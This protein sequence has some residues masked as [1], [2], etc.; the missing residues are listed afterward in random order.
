M[1]PILEEMIDSLSAMVNMN[2]GVLIGIGSI[3]VAVVLALIAMLFVTTTRM[4]DL[5]EKMTAFQSSLES[6]RNGLKIEFTN[7][8]I[9]TG[10]RGKAIFSGRCETYPT[11]VAPVGIS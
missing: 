2:F 7:L 10:F 3:T 9:I 4:S 1:I 6:G 8:E 5:N 11:T